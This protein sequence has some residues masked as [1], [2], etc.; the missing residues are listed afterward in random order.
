[1]WSFFFFNLFLRSLYS[2]I[3]QSFLVTPKLATLVLYTS[4]SSEQT[5][6]LS[7]ADQLS[8]WLP[9]KI[10]STLAKTLTA[11]DWAGTYFL[12][13][14]L[15]QHE[16]FVSAFLRL[17]LHCHFYIFRLIFNIWTA[18]FFFFSFVASKVVYLHFC[19]DVSS[20]HDPSSISQ[21]NS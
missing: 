1:M 3:L 16:W 12:P 20:F 9:I 19:S 14:R 6:S 2:L 7:M 4:Y 17:P 18:L 10:L 21:R 5:C 11:F 15:K 8:P 13:T